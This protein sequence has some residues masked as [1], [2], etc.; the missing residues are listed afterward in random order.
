MT[1]NEANK[2]EINSE[3]NLDKL[4]ELVIYWQNLAYLAELR[5]SEL[6]PSLTLDQLKDIDQIETK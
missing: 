6:Q 2:I 1:S 3:T 4:R 5:I